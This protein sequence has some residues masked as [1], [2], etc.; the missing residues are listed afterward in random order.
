M[1]GK[2]I[3]LFCE[4]IHIE[5]ENKYIILWRKLYIDLILIGV[6]MGI[7]SLIFKV[8]FRLSKIALG[9]SFYQSFIPNC[10]LE[11]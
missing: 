11:F 10:V 7:S 3:L 1:V 5:N 4:T 2:I 8:F 6:C 9:Q